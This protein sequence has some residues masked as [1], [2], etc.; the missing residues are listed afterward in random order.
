MSH[1]KPVDKEAFAKQKQNEERKKKIPAETF[2]LNHKILSC[3][4]KLKAQPNSCFSIF[5]LL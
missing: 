4:M 2:K 5:L 3:I 1:L